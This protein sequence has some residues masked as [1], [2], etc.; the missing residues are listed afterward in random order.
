MANKKSELQDYYL[1]NFMNSVM[2]R[3]KVMGRQRTF[4]TY[5]S[6]L[7]SFTAF[8]KNNDLALSEMDSDIMMLYEAYLRNRV[9]TYRRRKTGQRFSVKWERCMEEITG[10]YDTGGSK[11]LLPIIKCSDRDSRIQYQSAMCLVNRN[12]KSVGRMAGVPL[13]LTMYVAR[14]SW[15][16]VAKSKNIPISVISEG[17]GHDSERT[18]QIYLASLDV[19]VIDRANSLILNSI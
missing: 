7:K 2:E 4:E 10:R 15:A 11:Y 5:A 18:T 14:H 17:M 8:R 9:L 6:T 12:L 13:P 1:F 3:L 19:S 16:T